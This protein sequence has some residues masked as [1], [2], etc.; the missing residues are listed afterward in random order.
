M[1]KDAIVKTKNYDKF[2]IIVEREGG[3]SQRVE[4]TDE[5][6]PPDFDPSN[7]F[8]GANFVAKLLEP[9]TKELGFEDDKSA[10][11]SSQVKASAVPSGMEALANF[12]GTPK[13]PLDRRD[14]EVVRMLV[15]KGELFQFCRILHAS[16]KYIRKDQEKRAGTEWARLFKCYRGGG[17]ASEV[18]EERYE[19]GK[20][21]RVS[22]K[23]GCTS[24]IRILKLLNDGR[25]VV[26]WRWRHNHP[27]GG[28]ESDSSVRLS[29][30]VKDYL[31]G[32]AIKSVRFSKIKREC[33]LKAQE[34]GFWAEVDKV[35]KGQ[36]NYMRRQVLKNL[37]IKGGTILESLRAW[38]GWFEDKSF[39]VVFEE[40]ME[41]T[42]PSHSWY[43]AFVS[44]WQ[45]KLLQE[46]GR[47]I[48]LDT[49]SG[50]AHGVTTEDSVML[51]TIIVK[52][53]TT[54]KEAPA[55]FMITNDEHGGSV[56]GWLNKL[57]GDLNLWPRHILIDCSDTQMNAVRSVYSSRETD[58]KFCFW[59]FINAVVGRL[60]GTKM[61]KD[62]QHQI[63]ERLTN[64]VYAE[65]KEDFNE[66]W[67]KHLQEYGDPPRWIGYFPNPR[68]PQ[69][70]RWVRA[71]GGTSFYDRLE[72][73]NFVGRFDSELLNE[74]ISSNHIRP[75]VLLYLLSSIILQSY[76]SR[77]ILVAKGDAKRVRD[78]A[79]EKNLLHATTVI[80]DSRIDNMVRCI[81][82]KTEV[83]SFDPNKTGTWYTV[84]AVGNHKYSCT[85]ESYTYC[86]SR[87][88]H[89]YLLLRK[90]SLLTSTPLDVV[91]DEIDQATDARDEITITEVN[92]NIIDQVS[93]D[94]RLEQQEPGTA[95]TTMDLDG[96]PHLEI[97]QPM[98]PN[99]FHRQETSRA[100][101]QY[102]TPPLQNASPEPDQTP[103]DLDPATDILEQPILNSQS[104]AQ[105][106]IQQQ[107]LFRVAHQ[108][109]RL[110]Q[111]WQAGEL[112]ETQVDAMGEVFEK[113]R[114]VESL[115][116]QLEGN[117]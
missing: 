89:I 23:C 27:V 99:E 84:E 104:S 8:Q 92:Q 52:D 112:S 87:C 114:E 111:R 31:V 115:Q 108:L 21:R 96:E 109:S 81:H 60:R 106:Q 88:K 65:T 94:V 7:P 56:K 34:D 69:I 102:H 55:G 48:C 85:C 33:Q 42:I 80:D 6:V 38:K 53:N 49:I 98:S 19:S 63:A 57:K 22:K 72:M 20:R 93:S 47:I 97:D 11:V 26:L 76:H 36:Y 43:M 25:Y 3:E 91:L 107:F 35:N 77:H 83:K 100:F 5:K 68:D 62:T 110:A 46:Y 37:S 14:E 2:D 29:K 28:E 70:D 95:E 58:I 41:T 73:K 32:Q 12:R 61:S 67:R 71:L 44:P 82:G 66:L 113:L 50:V 24:T 15:S 79:E 10:Y 116:Q 30:P 16:T 45:K 51:C 4:V 17:R 86:V 13:P 18:T 1:V 105:T 54:G 40:N 74:Y 9:G 117:Y 64:M 101:E 90:Q 59:Y 103:G 78:E 75:D 39:H